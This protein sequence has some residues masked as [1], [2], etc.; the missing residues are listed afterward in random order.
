MKL[1]F[2]KKIKIF[3]LLI[4]LIGLIVGCTKINYNTTEKKIEKVTY[5]LSWLPH[6]D[7]TYL[8]ATKGLGYYEEEGLDV[9]FIPGK[10]STIS[11]KLV[12]AGQADIGSASGD[13]ALIART[14]GI[15]LVVLAIVYHDTPV[16]IVSLK[17]KNI[18]EPTDLHGKRVA[19]N[20]YAKN[21]QQYLAFLNAN[22]V[23][24]S[25]I[26]EINTKD[27]ILLLLEDK[28]DAAPRLT[29]E[30]V[31]IEKQGYQVNEICFKD[32]GISMY[33]GQTI[34]TNEETL[35]ENPEMIRKFIRATI[36][37]IDFTYNNPDKAS[38]LFFQEHSEGNQEIL[39]QQF[40]LL[41]PFFQNDYTEKHGLGYQ[42]EEKWEHT[43]QTLINQKL[44]N[45]SIEISEFYTNKF[46]D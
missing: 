24:E 6:P 46:L 3:L 44:I 36:K 29:T 45:D 21:Y 42:S 28:A 22:N 14:K 7:Q 31:L 34:I 4:F 18:T 32:N 8:W 41:L 30:K 20:K 43:M 27:N 2:K 9:E 16:C 39:K 15:P 19:V 1:T 23:D 17:E 13:S 38:E 33:G 5:Q 25:Q 26:K 11:T 12:G 37:G 35:Q 40:E 10:G